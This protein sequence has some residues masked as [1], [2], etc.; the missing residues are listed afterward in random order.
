MKTVVTLD[1]KKFSGDYC[2]LAH[3]EV[4]DEK[5]ICTAKYVSIEWLMGALKGSQYVDDKYYRIGKLP[6]NYYEGAFRRESNGDISGQIILIVPK[7]KFN[8]KFEKTSYHVPF[9]AL[10]FNCFIENGSLRKT[11]VFALKGNKWKKNTLL[12][13]HPFGNVDSHSHKVCWGSNVLPQIKDLKTLDVICSMFYDAPFNN[14]YYQ[15][16][17]TIKWKSKNLREVF[18]KLKDCQEFPENI[19]VKSG[20]NISSLMKN[21][22]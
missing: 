10:L 1:D 7:A 16:G 5:G 22:L 6:Q 21:F 8:I 15:A 14:D 20:K 13:K 18:E 9:P 11:Q 2:D 17:E 12:Y 19:L 4:V 3:V